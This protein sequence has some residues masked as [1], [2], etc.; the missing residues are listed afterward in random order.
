MQISIVLLFYNKDIICWN[1]DLYVLSNIIQITLSDHVYIECWVAKQKYNGPR[2]NEIFS[3]GRLK[4]NYDNL[5]E[6]IEETANRRRR[7]NDKMAEIKKNKMDKEWSTKL[8]TT[9]T[10]YTIELF[11]CSTVV[12][13]TAADGE[14][15]NL[16]L[17][18]S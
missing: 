7:D 6:N 4:K 18:Y 16:R 1:A 10:L 8:Y 13:W 15:T 11:V 5:E 9:H 3:R 17:C 12:F 14:V 2:K